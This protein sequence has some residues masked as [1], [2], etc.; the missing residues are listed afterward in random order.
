MAKKATRSAKKGR[1][2]KAVP[3]RAIGEMRASEVLTWLEDTG[4]TA[5]ANGVRALLMSTRGDPKYSAL[6][7]RGLTPAAGPESATKSR[8][9]GESLLDWLTNL[10][11]SPEERQR[12]QA[13]SWSKSVYGFIPSGDYSATPRVD[14]VDIR[15]GAP[16]RSL[17][18]EAMNVTL[19]HLRIFSY[20]GQGTRKVLF[21]FTGNHEMSAQGSTEVKF[22]QVYSVDAVTGEAGFAGYPVFIGLNVGSVGLQ[23]KCQ[24][25]FVESDQD[26]QLL[27]FME[28]GVFKQGLKL[29]NTWQPALKMVTEYATGLATG[30]IK[31]QQG[32]VVQQVDLGLYFSTAPTRPKMREGSYVVVQVDREDW[33]WSLFEYHPAA[34]EVRL[35][36]EPD[37]SLPFN[38]FIFSV[39]R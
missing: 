31:R 21:E 12:L 1:T 8:S 9:L 19:D 14:I 26:R 3:A 13:W 28:S 34:A 32:R 36:T 38:Y 10:S 16:D 30:L 6:V 2:K 24:T 20:P 25:V 15:N 22:S 27:S 18:D 37:K 33:D 4:Q 17:A 5:Q 39:S 35:K 11:R 23:F 29:L 7:R